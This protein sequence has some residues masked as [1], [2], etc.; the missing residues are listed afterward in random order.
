VPSLLQRAVPVHLKLAAVFRTAHPPQEWRNAAA[1]LCK[2]QPLANARPGRSHWGRG[3]SPSLAGSLSSIG[4]GHS[5]RP[6]FCG[7]RTVRSAQPRSQ[8]P[9]RPSGSEAAQ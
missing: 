4:R 5:R 8:S 2:C 3:G 6:L 7:P 9:R 1:P